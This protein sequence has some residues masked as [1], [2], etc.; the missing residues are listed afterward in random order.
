[1]IDGFTYW[2]SI[3]G[4]CFAV[5]SFFIEPSEGEE[6]NC[7]F[8]KK[9]KYIIKDRKGLNAVL[10][11]Y[12]ITNKEIE[13]RENI[14]LVV[15]T[16]LITGS[17]LVLGNTATNHSPKLLPYSTTSIFLFISWLYLLHVT[18]K[19]L[20]SVS[21][22]RVRAIEEVLTEYFKYDFGIHSY[23]RSKTRKKK[24]ENEEPVFWLR[25]R[26]GFWGFILILLSFSW[27]YLS[28]GAS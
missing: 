11:D 21:Y 24:K 4:I 23:L 27:L 25:L 28:L 14:N 8:G 17:I 16:I 22:S 5:I 9:I 10:K 26:R 7:D 6:Y 1:M 15:G 2:I 13:R 18:T 12:E 20:D 19:K 3:V